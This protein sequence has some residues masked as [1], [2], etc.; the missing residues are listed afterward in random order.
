MKKEI[1]GIVVLV[2]VYSIT[3]FAY[4]H[5]TFPSKDSFNLMIKQVDRIEN[6]VDKLLGE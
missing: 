3:A 4:M 5:S 2:L 1:L 6:K